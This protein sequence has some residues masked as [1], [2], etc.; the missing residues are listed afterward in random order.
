MG[1]NVHAF[2][3]LM[4]Q[5]GRAPLRRMLT[6][7]R[8]SL[9]VDQK[10]LIAKLGKAVEPSPYCEPALLALGAE[11]VDSIDVWDYENA[12]IVSD[13][14]KPCCFMHVLPVNKFNGHGFWQFSSDPLAVLHAQ[15]IWRHKSLLRVEH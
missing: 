10:F 15:R 6:V 13:L 8:Q 2:N 14:G 12:R 3:F 4:Y 5:A 1:V 7:G 11:S 9:D